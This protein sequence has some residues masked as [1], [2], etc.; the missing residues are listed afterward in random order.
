MKNLWLGALGLA[1]IGWLAT[2]VQA[3]TCVGDCDNSGLVAINEI[4]TCVNIAL[5]AAPVST[6]QAC[7]PDSSG[8]VAINELVLAVNSALSNC[9]TGG[10]PTPTPITGSAVCGNATPEAGE[11]CDDGNVFGGDGCAPNCTNETLRVGTFDSDKTVA[12]VQAGGFPIGPLHLE[13]SQTFRTG[14]VRNVDTM[15]TNNQ[16]IVKANE[17]PVAIRASE[18]HFEPV[19]VLGTICACVRGIPV[20]E[21]FGEGIAGSGSVGCND[22]GLTDVSYRLIQDHNTTPGDPGNNFTGTPDDPTCTD[23]NTL[24]GGTI[25]KAC[26]EQVDDDCKSAT[27]HPH[28][29]VCNGPRKLDRSGGPA[30]RGSAFIP[31]NTAIGQLADTGAC[32]TTGPVGGVCPPQ[33]ADYGPDCLPCTADDKDFGIA[34][35]LPTTT[36]TAE[37]AVFDSNNGEAVIDKDTTCGGDACKT[38]V[39]GANFDCDALIAD[40]TGGLSGGSLAVAFPALD[41]NLIGDNVTTTVFFNK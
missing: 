15:G 40:P 28:P 2:P 30:G 3:Q 36:G 27:L 1:A 33:F 20:P 22:A 23:Q 29:D 10:T 31:T 19:K 17:L 8:T 24:P 6:C 16:V 21:Q 32:D 37:A 9:S 39:T 13:G 14:T 38:S 25:S 34:N 12:V 35:N 7:D 26:K 11:D 4:V 5:E 18:L 41:A